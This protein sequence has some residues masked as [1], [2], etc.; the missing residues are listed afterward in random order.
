MMAAKHTHCEKHLW[1]STPEKERR[2]SP[3][4]TVADGVICVSATDELI[5][6]KITDISCQGLA[7]TFSSFNQIH[8]K[9]LTGDILI[10]KG[11]N[12]QDLFLSRIKGK[13]LAAEEIGPDQLVPARIRRRYRIEYLDLSAGTE[14][15]LQRFCS[16]EGGPG[17]SV[18]C[19]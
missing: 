17:L 10:G 5:V 19:Q 11:S 1:K 2:R 15:L 8:K 18:S 4:V 6:C 12:E 9:H 7:F 13:L 14:K 16:D 3:R